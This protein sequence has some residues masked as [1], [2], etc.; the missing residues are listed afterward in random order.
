MDIAFTTKSQDAIGAAVRI[1]AAQG[2]PSVEPIHLLDSLLQQGPGI[3]TTLLKH[4]DV[5]VPRL[6]A[7]ARA[8]MQSLPSASGS[9]VA[10]PQLSQLTFKV[11]NDADALAKER[12]DDYVSTEHLLVALARSGTNEAS[13]SLAKVGATGASLV[14]ALQETK[15]ST[16]VNTQDPEGTFQALEKYGIDLTALA[17]EGKIDPVLLSLSSTRL[18]ELGAAAI[19]RWT[20]A[21]C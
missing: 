13:K 4:L 16:R 7:S 19:R 20:P 18:L 12:S 9:T 2:N 11:L 14:Q 3:A 21:I 6:T 17:R 5:N 1:A 15:G 8:Q 10:A